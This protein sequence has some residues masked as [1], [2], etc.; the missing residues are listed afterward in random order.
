MSGSANPNL[1]DARATLEPARKQNQKA[2]HYAC[3]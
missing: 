3:K 2:N 1:E